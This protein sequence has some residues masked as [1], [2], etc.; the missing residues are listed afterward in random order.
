MAI[1]KLTADSIT[2]GAIA[3]T[4]AFEAYSTGL[5]NITNATYTKMEMATE[6]YDTDGDYD[7]STNYRFTPSVAG[8]YFC[9]AK[10]QS[11]G[12]TYENEEFIAMKFYKNNS[13]VSHTVSEVQTGGNSGTDGST[14]TTHTISSI[15]EFN[16]T[17]DYLEVFFL[18]NTWSDTNARVK[19]KLFGAYRIIE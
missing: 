17:T 18:L 19:N 8:K 16:G 2:S 9:Y 13:A 14:A 7:N 3:N 1:T 10:G 6:V 11:D 4:P 15:I 12:A 5:Q